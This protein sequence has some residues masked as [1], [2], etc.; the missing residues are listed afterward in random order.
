MDYAGD[1]DDLGDGPEDVEE[2]EDENQDN[3][4]GQ[5]T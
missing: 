5:Y 2:G 3:I 1:E 4:P